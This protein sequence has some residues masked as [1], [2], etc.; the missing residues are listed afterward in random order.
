VQIPAAPAGG[1]DPSR[2]PDIQGIHLGMTLQQ[3]LPVLKPLYPGPGT[4]TSVMG[5]YK[6]NVQ[7]L[8]APDKPW[9]GQIVAQVN[10]CTA[11]YYNACLTSFTSPSARLRINRLPSTCR[12]I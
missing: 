7:Y 9:V 12:E 5:V 1:I 8:N 3:A 11:D 6:I 2:L 10:P 4:G